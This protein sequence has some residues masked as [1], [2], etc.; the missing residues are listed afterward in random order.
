MF[1]AKLNIGAVAMGKA[2]E[3]QALIDI[4]NNTTTANLLS[5]IKELQDIDIDILQ[6]NPNSLKL[7]ILL[8]SMQDTIDTLESVDFNKIINLA[9]NIDADITQ[10]ESDKVSASNSADIANQAKQDTI[11]AI[12]NASVYDPTIQERRYKAEFFGLKL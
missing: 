9:D 8:K 1:E 2:R 5:S 4:L 12:S 11:D 6:T 10:I 7:I 3:L